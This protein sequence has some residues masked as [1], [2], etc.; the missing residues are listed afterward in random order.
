MIID[1]KVEGYFDAEN[2]GEEI[3]SDIDL[4]T[5]SWKKGIINGLYSFEGKGLGCE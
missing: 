1:S 2:D 3:P 4:V 5:W